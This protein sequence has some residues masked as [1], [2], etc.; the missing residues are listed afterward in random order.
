VPPPLILVLHVYVSNFRVSKFVYSIEVTIGKR[1][2]TA[3]KILS[4]SWS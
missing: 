1:Q 4:R 3:D 2:T